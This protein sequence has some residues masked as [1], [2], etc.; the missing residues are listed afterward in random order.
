MQQIKGDPRT[1]E[2]CDQQTLPAPFI[3]GLRA[4]VESG[5]TPK[6]VIACM[7]LAV[8][9]HGL[10]ARFD[11][12]ELVQRSVPLLNMIERDVKSKQRRT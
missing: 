12:A 3:D 2:A 4:A 10:A 11:S 8:L 1:G 5:L 9:M 6:Q 7:N